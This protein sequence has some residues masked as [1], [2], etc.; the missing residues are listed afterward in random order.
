MNLTRPLLVA[1]ILGFMGATCGGSG[2]VSPSGP[3][4]TTSATPV[5][6]TG[7][8]NIVFV[9]LDDAEEPMTSNMPRF[10]SA[11]I[12]KGLRFNNAFATTPLCGPS[13]SN[14]L[15]GEFTHNTGV[16]MNAGDQAGY[17]AFKAGGFDNNNIG[18]WLKAAGYKT[19]IFG[20]YE[21]DYPNTGSPGYSETYRSPG[22]GR[23]A[24]GDVRSD[25]DEQRLHAE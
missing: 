14:I 19:G 23:L 15:A 2:R 10:R 11:F 12:D 16:T 21:N 20:K 13:R 1:L 3:R 9:L 17:P 25:R 24:G 22:M 6:A 7:K 5:A 8:P 4:P 18:P